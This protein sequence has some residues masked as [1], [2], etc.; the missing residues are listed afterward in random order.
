[1]IFFRGKTFRENISTANNIIPQHQCT[2]SLQTRPR[3]GRLRTK[4]HADDAYKIAYQPKEVNQDFFVKDLSD[5]ECCAIVL[6]DCEAR[7][8]LYSFGVAGTEVSELRLLYGKNI[9][10]ANNQL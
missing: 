6:I 5:K 2:G 7:K 4:S 3:S 8:E 10:F 9:I 1:M